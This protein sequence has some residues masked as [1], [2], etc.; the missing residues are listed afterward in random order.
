MLYALITADEKRG[1]V[2]NALKKKIEEAINTIEESNF[3]KRPGTMC[4]HIVYKI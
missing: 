4:R 2:D 1:S 3:R